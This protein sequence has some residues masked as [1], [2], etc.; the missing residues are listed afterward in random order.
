MARGHGKDSRVLVNA[1]HMSG[2]IS[3]WTYEHRRA[4]STV[5]NLLS[6]GDQFLP[7][8]LAGRVALV[9]NYDYD[10]GTIGPVIDTA[11]Q[12]TD[13]LLTTICPFGLT[14][15]KFAFIA[16]GNLSAREV[17]ASVT[18]AVRINA[19][20]TPNDGVDIGFLLHAVTA[21]TADGQATSVDNTASSANG[22][23]AS[24]HVTAFAGLTSAVLKVQH[25]TD[26]SS[27]A[28]LITFTTATGT[29][30]ERKTATGTINRYLRA[31]WDVTGTG[32][33]T[34]AIAA[35]RR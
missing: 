26:N 4:L 29:T 6:D 31:W 20:G 21:E 8:L 16:A 34:F 33:I 17:T 14:V 10:A 11:E 28:D 7:G 13:G 24:L 23:V 3:G 35:A 30:W 25:S 22:A 12:T 32:S 9:G 19:E 1:T 18:D 15:G 5:A 2:H 27:W